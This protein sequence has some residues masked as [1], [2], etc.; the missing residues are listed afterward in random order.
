MSTKQKSRQCPH[1]ES[2]NTER[3][4]EFGLCLDCQEPFHHSN[5]DTI[6]AVVLTNEAIGGTDNG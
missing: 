3:M 1:C 5:S 2:K 4:G 6:D